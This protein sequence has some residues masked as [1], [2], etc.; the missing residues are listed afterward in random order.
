MRSSWM[1]TLVVAAL[2]T[3]MVTLT[4]CRNGGKTV[5]AG[6]A[7][8]QPVSFSDGIT[9]SDDAS[10]AQP[11]VY[12]ITSQAQ[13]NAVA[14]AGLIPGEPVDFKANDVVLLS[15]GEKPTGGYWVRITSIS[16][17]GDELFV[18]GIANKPGDDA[19]TT[20]A[21]TYPYHAVLIEKTSAK[22]AVP[23]ITSVTGQSPTE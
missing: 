8:A 16:Q 6:L 14:S 4:A 2:L 20:Q 19:I 18:S 17:V 9:G 3:P 23:E 12:L 10:L 22:I 7:L 21:L 5:D 1:K 11:G 15:G 13:L